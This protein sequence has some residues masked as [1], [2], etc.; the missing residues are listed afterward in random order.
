MSANAFMKFLY[1]YSDVDFK[2]T[3]FGLNNFFLGANKYKGGL[4]GTQ[5]GLK[6]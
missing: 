4:I 1:I 5:L 6:F 3:P 2:G